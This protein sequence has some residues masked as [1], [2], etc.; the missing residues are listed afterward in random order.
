MKR[1]KNTM[2]AGLIVIGTI[3]GVQGEKALLEHL[4]PEEVK[5]V[6]AHNYQSSLAQARKDNKLLF[7]DIGAS[8]CSS[9][10][11]LDEQIF[12][13]ETIQD[14]LVLFTLLKIESDVDTQAYE[15]VK[16]QYRNS[17]VGFPTYLVVDPKTE[18]VIKKWTIDID[19][20]TLEGIEQEFRKL[21]QSYN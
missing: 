5:Q 14:A 16:K 8:Y 13:Q 6:W 9:C 4:F 18:T 3:L 15:E 2:G 7:I 1:Y 20:L 17:I 10:K 11:S 21:A 12:A 19:Q